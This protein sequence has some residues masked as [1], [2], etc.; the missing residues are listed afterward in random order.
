MN[1][2]EEIQSLA[3]M[4]DLIEFGEYLAVEW[5]LKRRRV[6]IHGALM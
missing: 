3:L 1:F 6:S 2:V 4:C 5:S